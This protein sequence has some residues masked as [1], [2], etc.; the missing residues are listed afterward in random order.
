VAGLESSFCNSRRQLNDLDPA[1]LES[2]RRRFERVGGDGP[3]VHGCFW[4]V[5][6]VSCGCKRARAVRVGHVVRVVRVVRVGRVG[7][8]EGRRRDVAEMLFS[9]TKI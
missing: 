2:L 6:H 9:N 7:H 5:V 8:D 3:L 1:K 4:W